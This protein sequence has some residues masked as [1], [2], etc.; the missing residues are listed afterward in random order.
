MCSYVKACEDAGFTFNHYKSEGE[1]DAENEDELAYY[2][3]VMSRI[4]K[5]LLDA[6]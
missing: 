6:I 2:L 1:Y 4:E 3:E 5:E